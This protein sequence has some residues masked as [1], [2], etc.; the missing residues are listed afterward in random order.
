M[1][2]KYPIQKLLTFLNIPKS[3]D[4]RWRQSEPSPEEIQLMKR[5]QEIY[6]DHKGRYKFPELLMNFAPAIRL[7]LTIKK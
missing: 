4:Y 2:G 1:R 5:I 6:D 3:N 7:P